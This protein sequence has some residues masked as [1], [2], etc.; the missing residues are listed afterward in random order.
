M[1]LVRAPSLQN[2]ALLVIAI[3]SFARFYYFCFYVIERYVDPSFR[4]SGLGS[5]ARYLLKVRS[6]KEEGRKERF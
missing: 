6:K 4:F 5:A 2:A 1:L 3:W